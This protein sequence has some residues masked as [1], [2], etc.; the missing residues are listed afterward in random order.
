M[1]ADIQVIDDYLMIKMPEEIDHHGALYISDE[2]DSY[3]VTGQ[4]ANV[5]FDFERT[6]FMDSSGI[7]VIVGRYRKMQC[8]GGKVYIV[9]ASLRMRK[10]LYMSGLTDLVEILASDQMILNQEM[11]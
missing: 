11:H 9:G 8:I 3:I 4:I 1:N 6:T 7:G 2:A 5:I 10:M